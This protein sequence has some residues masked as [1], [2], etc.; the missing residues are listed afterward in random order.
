MELFGKRPKLPRA[1]FV[2]ALAFVGGDVELGELT[3]VWPFA[4]LRGDAERITVGRECN[5]QDGAV[6]HADPGAP[7]V[8]GNRVS[9]GHR[10]VVHGAEVGSNTLVGVGA[11][12]LNGARIG[13]W[14]VIGAGAVVTEGTV[15]PDGSVVLGVPARVVRKVTERDRKLIEAVTEAYVSRTRRILGLAP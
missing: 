14:C 8:V 13:E 12:V 4:V 2:H 10:A 7:A 5:I 11:V 9:I 6:I 3:S 15:V 1:C